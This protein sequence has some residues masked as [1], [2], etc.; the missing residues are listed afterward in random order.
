M[1]RILSSRGFIATLALIAILA[2]LVSGG[3]LKL[4]LRDV[5]TRIAVEKDVTRLLLYTE[6]ILFN[7]RLNVD[8]LSV[9]K[10]SCR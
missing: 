1:P 8:C 9:K 10:P 5:L 6:K 3:M 2:T 7:H 4:Y